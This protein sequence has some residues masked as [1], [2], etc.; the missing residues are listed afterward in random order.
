MPD[1][2]P[3]HAEKTL[4][5]PKQPGET[6]IGVSIPPSTRGATSFIQSQ[7]SVDASVKILDQQ[8][9]I[10]YSQDSQEHRKLVLDF[11]NALR[12]DGIDAELDQ[13]HE[14]DPPPKGW[15][16]WCEK[17]IEAARF[18]LMI[19]TATYR[20]RVEG[21]EENPE[22]GKGVCWEAH[23]I[24]ND[25]YAGKGHNEK[26]IPVL[27]NGNTEDAIPDMARG[28]SRYTVQAPFEDEE[29]KA[30]LIR[31]T[32]RNR[33]P[34]P[35][36]GL[37]NLN[38]A[39]SHGE[40]NDT[41]KIR[42]NDFLLQIDR[43]K[44]VPA[45]IVE[46]KMAGG[47]A[48]ENTSIEQNGISAVP[49]MLEWA[50][51]P[52]DTPF[53]V[54]LGEYG[55]GKTWNSQFLALK[56]EECLEKTP[57]DSARV[58]TPYYFDLR[59]ILK[60]KESLLGGD[61][62]E[63]EFLLDRLSARNTPSDKKPLAGRAILDAVQ[64]EGALII[65]DGLDEV[66]AHKRD[67]DWGQKFIDL[68]FSALPFSCWP[69]HLNKESESQRPGK[70][71]LTCRTH[72][73][74]SVQAL[75][76]QILGVGREKQE[77]ARPRAWQMLPFSKEQILEYLERHLP[78]QNPQIVFDL[79]A[80][81]HD[82]TEVSRRPV[83]LK[84]V[85]LQIERIEA[86]R[87][88]G[89]TVNGASIYAFMVEEWLKRDIGKHRLLEEDKHILMQDLALFMWQKGL[90][91]ISWDRLVEWFKPWL[92]LNLVRQA[93]YR[94]ATPESLLTDL[95]NATFLVRP[96]GD[97]FAFAHTSILEY[98]LALRLHRS[99][100]KDEI[101]AWN[102]LKPS[103]ETLDFLLQHQQTCEPDIRE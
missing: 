9:F 1:I 63:L 81:V 27:L 100:E 83:G 23:F 85:S 42:P 57:S 77:K 76:S 4:E 2:S 13:Y 99:L 64:K 86:A 61:L 97:A 54:L 60:D 32:G 20:Q 40:K 58:P 59:N 31:L 48:I 36:L 46:A 94:D 47:A 92:Y 50:Y 103:P 3:R 14:D 53:A 49:A 12:R 72:Y 37:P 18:V 82:L 19:C 90:R 67:E 22:K 56:L 69:R 66:L 84:M 5:K 51:D 68:L 35:P 45:K 74:K 29:Y 43:E 65:F 25:L 41:A 34:K 6:G 78:H 16:L 39:D 96:D 80:S 24:R 79:L 8:V 52:N 30:L 62:P 102:G 91:E 71:L 21:K 88:A 55:M 101:D 7:P 33:T 10:S 70:I 28:Y 73:F 93:M 95:R 38:P 17:Q 89:E 26:F 11:S 15:P 75:N 44:D 98:F 87:R